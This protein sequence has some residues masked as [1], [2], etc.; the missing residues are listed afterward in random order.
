M[1]ASYLANFDS[2]NLKVLDKENKI[3][4]SLI[5]ELNKF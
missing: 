5:L 1:L 3:D 2:S 4:K